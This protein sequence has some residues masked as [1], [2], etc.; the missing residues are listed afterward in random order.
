MTTSY[1]MPGPLGVATNNEPIDVGT[2]VRWYSFTPALI[3]QYLAPRTGAYSPV[4]PGPG[5]PGATGSAGST[6]QTTTGMA[7]PSPAAVP[8]PLDKATRTLA[9]TAYG[10]GGTANV[11]EEMAG[12]ANVLVRQQKARGY[13]TIDGFIRSD[14]TFA[15]AAHDGNARYARLMAASVAEIKADSG[16]TAAVLGAVNALSD[17]PTDYAHGA[18]F[19]DGADIKT[20][21]KNHPKVRAGIRITDASHNIYGIASKDVPGEEWWRDKEGNKTK[22]RGKWDYKFESTAGWGGTIFWKYNADFLK[23]TANKEHD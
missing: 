23:A 6:P 14:T 16:M 20:N 21:Y 22:L 19:W 1:R 10:E 2:M 13:K 4:N 15:F 5:L 18:Y 7:A 11:P 9:A 12:I 8:D 3:E 17:A